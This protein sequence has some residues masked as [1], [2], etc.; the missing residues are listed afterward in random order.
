M[1]SP[2]VRTQPL[3][4][5]RLLLFAASFAAACASPLALGQQSVA[6]ADAK[7]NPAVSSSTL[8]LRSIPVVPSTLGQ[9]DVPQPSSGGATLTNVVAITPK[10]VIVATAEGNRVVGF[11]R[12][13]RI[14]GPMESEFA[15]YSA[16]AQDAWR[17]IARTQREDFAG[18]E[19][20]LDNLWNVL[21]EKTGPTAR[22]ISAALL[23]C[24]LNRGAVIASIGPYLA[25]IA[26]EDPTEDPAHPD[27]QIVHRSLCRQ[28]NVDPQSGICWSLPPIFVPTTSLAAYAR[29]TSFAPAASTKAAAIENLYRSAAAFEA[30]RA[31]FSVTAQPIPAIASTDPA[32]TFLAT[33]VTSRTGSD[34]ER[35]AARKSLTA[36]LATTSNTNERAWIS[37]AIGRSLLIESDSEQRLIGLTYLLAVPAMLDDDNRYLAGLAIAESAVELA[38][39]GDLRSATVLRTELQDRYPS[40]P[41]LDWDAVRAFRSVAPSP[42]KQPPVP[43][44]QASMEQAP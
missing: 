17:A 37:A 41:A 20:L 26:A 36:K 12:I 27:T 44:P 10:G 2:P 19:P 13:A 14:D 25:L 15:A 9:A 3:D 31:G 32:V 11:H 39:Q 23:S 40:H 30:Q 28:A 35:G 34:K 8:V 18:A 7:A 1:T 4:I 38:R 16:V 6:P 22:S 21:P 43:D 24:K 42:A 29:S 5:P 33:L